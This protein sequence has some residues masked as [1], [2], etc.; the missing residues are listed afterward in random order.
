MPVKTIGKERVKIYPNNFEAEQSILCCI[1]IDGQTAS[2]VV[3]LLAEVDFYN[4]RHKSIFNAMQRLHSLTIAIDVITVNDRL[5]KE[6]SS[7]ADTL[8]YLA[9]LATVLPSSAN[10]RQYLRI[11]K[12]DTILRSLIDGCNQIIEEAYKSSDASEVVKFAEALIYSIAKE[13]TR[14]DLE[15]ISEPVTALMARIDAMIKDK[16]ALR[17][18]MTGF[19]IFDQKTN[20]LQK[21]DLIILAARPSV[22]KTSFALNVVANIASTKSTQKK[23]IAVFSLEM[24]AVQLAQRIL[25]NLSGVS[26]TDVSKGELKNDADKKIWK[27]TQTLGESSVY[28]DDSSMLTPYDILGKARRLSSRA[29]GLDLIV[30]DYLQLMS[31]KGGKDVSRQ[32]TISEISRMLKIVAKELHC[33]VM[34]LSQMSR[35]IESRTDKAPRLSDLRESGAIEQDADIVM[36]LSREDES[37]KNAAEFPILL[38]IAKHRNGELAK[39]RYDWEGPYIRFTESKN[40]DMKSGSEE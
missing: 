15:H 21:G 3:P 12:R 18:L 23:T 7:E 38:E 17:G 14:N 10:F 16:N 2:E 40:Q 6:N 26:M 33:P 8:T 13:Q 1:L 34:V 9:E 5:V 39:I 4:S 20:G 19:P 36:F 22:G 24:P 32:E 31:G 35:G 27:I 25:C 29:K 30:V 28:I 11:I 37:V